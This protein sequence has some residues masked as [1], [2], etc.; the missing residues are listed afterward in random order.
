M[1]TH[2]KGWTVLR[3]DFRV[4]HPGSNVHSWLQPNPNDETAAHAPD[5][6]RCPAIVT[7]S[8]RTRNG[9]SDAAAL[10]MWEWAKH[11]TSAALLDGGSYLV[12]SAFRLG[13]RPTLYEASFLSFS[14]IPY[15]LAV[16]ECQI[17]PHQ[18][19]PSL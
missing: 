12:A 14:S 13:W 9:I 19:T 2:A 8:E 1:L 6:T 10:K 5:C 18:V 3:R 16:G 17:L 7:E 11:F 4:H 15:T